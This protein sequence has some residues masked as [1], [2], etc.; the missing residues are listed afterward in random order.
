M[1]NLTTVY[2]LGILS[3]R[4]GLASKP[5]EIENVCVLVCVVRE[6]NLFLFPFLDFLAGLIIELS[7]HK[8]DWR[9]R[10]K[11]TLIPVGSYKG[12]RLKE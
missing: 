5:H 12:V 4:A 7:G 1:L 6:K 8:T 9:G 3:S 11:F 2:L 10:D